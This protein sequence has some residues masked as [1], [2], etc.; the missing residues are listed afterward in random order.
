[1]EISYGYLYTLKQFLI[2]N[3][4]DKTTDIINSID[5]IIKNTNF[6]VLYDEKK[7]IFS[8]GYNVEENKITD[9]YYDLLAS[10]ARQ[11][12]L[13]A[14]AKQDVPVKH[15]SSLSRTLTS[16]NR[17]KGLISW[18]GTAFEYLMPNINIKTYKGSLLDES[19][20][21]MLMSQKEYA[22]ELN[23]PWGISEAAFNLRDFNNN[24]QY[25]AFG[26]PWLG[27]KRGLEEDMVVSPYAIFLSL[28][29]DPVEAIYNLRQL[30]RQ[31]MYGEYGFYESIDY[32]ISRLQYGKTYEP[33]KT[34][35]AH[36]QGLIL[37]SINNLINNEILV[38]RFS[39]NPEIEAVDILLQ[40]RM[41]EKAIITKEKKEK[42][43]K[44]KLKDY[45][46]Y[47]EKVY[48]KLNTNLNTSN[49]ISNGKY[50]IV[51]TLKGTG[52][53]KYKNLLINRYKETADYSQGICF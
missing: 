29:Y 34:Y 10:E 37:L 28:K 44:L 46:N 48:T 45:E 23:L 13:I 4:T 6:S 19:C 7:R 22:K 42:V 47:S 39:S 51:S 35:M 24:Y 40:E 36:H 5:N 27:L 18:S 2:E 21:F 53:S 26:I 1:M 32:T 50:T 41:P 49:V 25:K 16:L 52:Y 20:R 31:D 8:I 30:E 11:A 33:V 38:K 17:Y 9:S 15:W 14:I 3:Q 12:S 43:Q